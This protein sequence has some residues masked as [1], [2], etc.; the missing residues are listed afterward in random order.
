MDGQAQSRA[1]DR[2][3]PGQDQRGRS[4]RN[5]DFDIPPLDIEEWVEKSQRGLENALRAKPLD[6]REQ[7]DRQIMELQEAY[8]EA[9]LELDAGIN[10]SPCRARTRS[11]R[12]DPPGTSTRRH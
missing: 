8:G 2:N 9:I 3:Y 11:D 6:V 1:S 5:F 4:Q 12:D 10:C 7:Y